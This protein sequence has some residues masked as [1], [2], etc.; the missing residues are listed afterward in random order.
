MKEA[1]EKYFSASLVKLLFSTD[2]KHYN[3]A[4]VQLESAI[5]SADE[6]T[7]AAF[8]SVA[9]IAAARQHKSV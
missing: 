8:V 2:F 6:R 3:L 1:A 9:D 7:L 4:I 5:K